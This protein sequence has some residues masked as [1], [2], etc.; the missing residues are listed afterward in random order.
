[1]LIL[2]N[3]EQQQAAHTVLEALYATKPLPEL[4]SALSQEQLLHAAVLADM[5][6]VPDVGLE[7]V[8]QLTNAAQSSSGLSEAAMQHLLHMPVHPDYLQPLLKHVLL[9]LLGDLEAVWAD[10]ALA[11]TLLG[12]P[13]HVVE[14]LLSYDELQVCRVHASYASQRFRAMP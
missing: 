4:L 8:Q 1:M 2:Q 10:E 9:P 7:A 5:W 12:L 6:E 11:K 13:L 3:A 14:Q